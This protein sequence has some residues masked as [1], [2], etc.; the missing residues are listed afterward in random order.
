M[1]TWLKAEDRTH[2]PELHAR[3]VDWAVSLICVIAVFARIKDS[4][5][6]HASSPD[7]VSFSEANNPGNDGQSFQQLQSCHQRVVG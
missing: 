3:V 6:G 7:S 5:L 4:G 2:D 1:S